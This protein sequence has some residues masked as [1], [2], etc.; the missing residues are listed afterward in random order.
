MSMKVGIV[1]GS[2]S[3]LPTMERAAKVLTELEVEY[4]MRILS[5]HRTPK[6]AM[7][8]AEGAQDRG[9]GV[10]I[11]GAGMAAHLGGVVAAHTMLP[12]IGVPMNASLGGMDALLSIVQMPPGVPVGS[13]GIG[14]AGARNAA[15]FAVRIL[16][17]QDAELR[18]RLKLAIENMTEKVLADDASIQS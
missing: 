14:S 10:L 8:W 6:Q 4:E 16:A 3:D 15:W 5:A 12:V 9:V 11:C 1:M 7:E 13:V 18:Q 17:L 2:K